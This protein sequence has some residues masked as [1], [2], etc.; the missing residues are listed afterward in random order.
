[1]AVNLKKK[2]FKILTFFGPLSKILRFY[3]VILELII[4]TIYAKYHF[5]CT[6]YENVQETIDF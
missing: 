6:F 1:M 3:H 4:V 2:Y 5:Y